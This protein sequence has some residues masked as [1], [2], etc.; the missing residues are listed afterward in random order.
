MKYPIYHIT[1]KWSEDKRPSDDYSRWPQSMFNGLPNGR[2]WN[3]TS[4]YIMF[5]EEFSREK[6]I[7]D[8][9]TEWWPKYCIDH[10]LRNPSEPEFTVEFSHEESFCMG[11]FSHW[12][13]DVGQSDA[14]FIKDFIEYVQRMQ[15]R[16]RT[17]GKYIGEGQNKFWQEKYCLMGAEEI[18]RWCG[19][20]EKHTTPP[21][22]CDGCKKNGV[23]R[24]CH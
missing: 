17:E 21:C 20:P 19:D 5:K 15:F 8:C 18:E 10:K 4:W 2:F 12:T 6:Y 7:E 1:V 16:N 9:L 24:I 14:E 13:F 22:R 23:L 11:W 3:M